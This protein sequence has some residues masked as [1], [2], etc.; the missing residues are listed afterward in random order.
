MVISLA[1]IPV[2]QTLSNVRSMSI[3]NVPVALFLLKPRAMRSTFLINAC[4]E[5][6]FKTVLVIS[7]NFQL[8]Q[9]EV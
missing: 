7:D 6:P 2:V 4:V 8:S 5:C 1:I 3:N 9:L